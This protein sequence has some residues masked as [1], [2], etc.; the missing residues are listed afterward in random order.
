M[1]IDRT[2]FTRVLARALAYKDCGKD[3]DANEC[4]RTLVAMLARAG[5][6]SQFIHVEDHRRAATIMGPIDGS[7]VG[8]DE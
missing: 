8:C 3:N 7:L 6:A 2:P 4:G 1:T 5:I